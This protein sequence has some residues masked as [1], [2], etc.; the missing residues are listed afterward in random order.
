MLNEGFPFGWR[1]L[2]EE[3]VLWLIEQPLRTSPR[4]PTEG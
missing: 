3:V 2:D 1:D 4:A